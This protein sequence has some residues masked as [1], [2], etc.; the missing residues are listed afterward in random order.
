[1]AAFNFTSIFDPHAPSSFL[2]FYMI[3][4]MVIVISRNSSGRLSYRIDRALNNTIIVHTFSPKALSPSPPIFSVIRSSS[5]PPMVGHDVFS[6]PC[7][8][9]TESVM[10]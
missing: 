6:F 1:M 7:H 10:A 8:Y 5:E 3:S 9:Y 4:M 2:L